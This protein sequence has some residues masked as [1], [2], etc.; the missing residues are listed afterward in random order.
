[1]KFVQRKVTT[2]KSK[3]T[4]ADFTRLKEQFLQDVVAMVEME[5]IPPELILN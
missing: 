5:E 2:A 3:H 1:M 4:I